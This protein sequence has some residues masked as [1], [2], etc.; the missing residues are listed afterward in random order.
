MRTDITFRAVNIETG[1]F[2]CGNFFMKED[3]PFIQ[4]HDAFFEID[5]K[6]LGRFTGAYDKNGICIF[7]GDEVE[8]YEVRYNCEDQPVIH[9]IKGYVFWHQE[10]L[11]FKV[12]VN[13]SSIF[14]DSAVITFF[15]PENWIIKGNINQVDTSHYTHQKTH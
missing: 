1:R 6:T 2:V 7:E 15:D 3:I 9:N 11:R 5:P 12:I 14:K 4:F 8:L 10:E 13:S